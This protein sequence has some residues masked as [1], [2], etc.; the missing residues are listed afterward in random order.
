MKKL[1]NH[2]C[3]N[4][5]YQNLFIIL[6]ITGGLILVFRYGLPLIIP[7]VLAFFI[8]GCLRPV[9]DVCI[10]RLHCSEKTASLL[11]LLLLAAILTAL[12]KWGISALIQQAE[13]LVLYLPFYREQFFD[14]LGTCCS[15]VDNGFHLRPGSSL[16][17]TTQTLTNMFADFNTN[18]LPKLTSG[19]ASAVKYT[20]SSI[21]FLFITLYATLCMLIRY[22]RLFTHGTVVRQIRCIG[23]HVI[24]M[25]FLYLRA[26]GLIALIQ[27]LL[28]SI[29]LRLLQSP[30]FLPLALLIGIVDALPVFGSGTILVPWAVI[31]LLLGDIKMGVGLLLL[32][33]L[34]TLNRQLLEPR[35]LGQKLGISTLLTLFLMYVGYQLFGLF[36]FILGPVGYL[37]GKEIYTSLSLQNSQGTDS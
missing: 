2:I 10:R 23:E 30:Y 33:G 27:A 36:G 18:I 6:L 5:E 26:E 8:A 35:L 11:V 14:G 1:W 9:V 37:I 15:Y 32:W 12:C 16:S 19:T 13:N 34:C 3:Q 29:M 20:F 17:Y 21:L 25:L 22:P 4:K 31:R 7:F 24:H 28:C